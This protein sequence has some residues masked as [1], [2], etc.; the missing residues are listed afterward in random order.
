[1]NE[2]EKLL[3]CVENDVGGWE[4]ITTGV[5]ERGKEQNSS[6]L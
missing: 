2:S 4:E 5:C 1:M 3:G 6:G